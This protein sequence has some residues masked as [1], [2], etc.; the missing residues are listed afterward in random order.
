[1]FFVTFHNS[2]YVFNSTQFKSQFQFSANQENRCRILYISKCWQC[3]TVSFGRN[4]TAVCCWDLTA[5]V[6]KSVEIGIQY[7]VSEL[8]T[9]PKTYVWFYQ[10][11]YLIPGFLSKHDSV[12][13]SLSAYVVQKATAVKS[14]GTQNWMVQ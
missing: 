13:E 5:V 1:M 6:Q 14:C 12:P 2:I 9:K 4:K 3:V 8:N 11:K 7:A 10:M